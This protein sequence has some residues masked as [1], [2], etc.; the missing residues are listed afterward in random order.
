MQNLS[1]LTD[2][3][4]ATLFRAACNNGDTTTMNAIEN[5]ADRRDRTD[6]KA[7]RDRERWATVREEWFHWAWAQFLAAE[8]ACRGYLLNRAGHAAGI[9]P[10]ALWS[11]PTGRAMR[12]AS[13]ELLEFWGRSPRITVSEYRKQKRHYRLAS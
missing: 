4:L 1:N 2:D 3:Q 12:Y 11:G 6:R 5:E 7:R 13:E 10:W 9:D 8:T